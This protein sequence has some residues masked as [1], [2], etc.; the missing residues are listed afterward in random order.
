M[1]SPT[2]S[3]VQLINYETYY[4]Q[5]IKPKLETIDL[6]LKT[7]PAPFHVY[8]VAHILEIEVT[9]LMTHIQ[10][11]NI[12]EINVATFFSIALIG[13]SEICKL[14]SR[15]W[16]YAKLCHYTPEIVAEIYQLDLHKVQLAFNDLNLSQIT[17]EKL[18]EIFKR[19]H[20]TVF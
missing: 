6:F 19:I 14:L 17:A 2:T 11:L 3:Y 12:K 8:A 15:Q 4:N 7:N 1:Y 13:S 5:F 20:L 18:S 16:H 9:E 10:N